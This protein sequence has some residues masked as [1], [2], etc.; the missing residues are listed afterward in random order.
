VSLIEPKDFIPLNHLDYEDTLY[1]NDLS[2][3][4]E[5]N[6]ENKQSVCPLR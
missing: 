3:S 5:I 2:E 4:E 1:E 6:D